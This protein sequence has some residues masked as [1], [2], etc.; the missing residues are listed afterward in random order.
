MIRFCLSL[1]SKSP[2]AYEEIRNSHIL[3]LPSTRTLRDY[4]NFIKP[5]PGFRKGVINDLNMITK[6]YFNID[7]YIV[8]LFEEMKIKSN[9][10]L[11]K[12]TEELIGFL[13][14][15]DPWTQIIQLSILKTNSFT[16]NVLV[17]FF[18]WLS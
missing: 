12:Q 16:T 1:L 15:G 8:L 3:T 4:K 6:D 11:D 18:T 5:E 7:R 17:F 2:S 14:L 10:V 13:D 9:L